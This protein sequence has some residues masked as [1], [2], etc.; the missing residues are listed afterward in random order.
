MRN[1]YKLAMGVLSIGVLVGMVMLGLVLSDRTKAIRFVG[2]MGA[3]INLGNTLDS[4][5]LREYR[6]DADD[7]EY[8]T[9][10]GNPRADAETFC[11]MKA[12]GFGTVRIPVTWE[13]HLDEDYQISESWLNRV[14]EVVD[15]ALEED[16]YVILNMHHEKWLNLEMEREEEI[17]EEFVTVWEQIAERFRN[18]DEKLLFEAMNEP[19]LRDSEYE[20]T[21]GTEEMRS[22]VNGLNEVFVKTVRDTGG[23]NKKRYLMVCPYA[24]NH[25]SEA[26]QGLVVPD[27]DRVIVSVHMYTPYSFCQKEDGDITWDT[28]ETRERVAGAFRE[29]NSLFVEQNIPV[30]LTEFGCVDKGNT[31][32]RVTWTEHYMEQ[33]TRYGIPCIWWDC[34]SYGLLDRENK[35]WKF[36][37]IVE[38]LT[39]KSVKES[40]VSEEESEKGT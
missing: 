1:K 19:R 13:D 34:G 30:I 17:R 39:G 27:D 16:L 26:M 7:L 25:E 28:E 36:P 23:E 29:M 21:S 24:T 4:T 20:W 5:G 12:A 3:G 38:V 33:S 32:E 9:F 14:Q 10:W 40:N 31:Q 11:A 35:T 15:M 18:Y 37:E 2:R 6:T 22:M 8:E